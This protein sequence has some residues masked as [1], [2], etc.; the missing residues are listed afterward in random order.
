MRPPTE[1]VAPFG[2]PL[3]VPL[4][5]AALWM[6]AKLFPTVGV[7]PRFTVSVGLPARLTVPL[8]LSWS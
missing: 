8:T 2:S 3:K 6:M 7:K 5:P 4:M 1:S